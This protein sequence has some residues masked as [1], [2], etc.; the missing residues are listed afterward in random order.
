M[1]PD[2]PADP[3]FLLVQGPSFL[4][5]DMAMILGRHHSFFPADLVVFPTDAVCLFL[6]HLSVFNLIV[7][8]LVLAI[9]PVIDLN[10]AGM[11]RNMDRLG[12]GNR[13]DPH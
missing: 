11:P 4:A 6:A 5:G 1:I 3:V 2:L 9:Q 13:S 8:P 10:P 12:K 7:Y